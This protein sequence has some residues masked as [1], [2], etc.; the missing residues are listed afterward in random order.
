MWGHKKS[1]F[2]TRR[3]EQPP[4]SQSFRKFTDQIRGHGGR[5]RRC[6]PERLA[7]DWYL[8]LIVVSHGPREKSVRV[9]LFPNRE[10]PY[11]EMCDGATS[12]NN[13]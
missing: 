12:T 13:F 10:Y 9:R 2:E 6:V 7:P 3:V 8:V 5:R 1:C 11:S 4:N